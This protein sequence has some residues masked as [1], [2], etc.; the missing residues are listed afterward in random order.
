MKK[1]TP[2]QD[3]ELKFLR[4]IVDRCQDAVYKP[5]PLPNSKQNWWSAQEE[6]D[7]YVIELRRNDYHI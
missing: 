5:N 4:G 3:A 7:R 1:L 6:L 2:A